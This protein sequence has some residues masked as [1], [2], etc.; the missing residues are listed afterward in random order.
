MY[1]P[2]CG[3]QNTDG[4]KFCRA[5]GTELEALALVLS[6]R[7]APPAEADDEPKTADDWLALRSDGVRNIATGVCLLVISVLIGVALALFL[8]ASFDAPW[9][10]IWIVLV[11][12][13]AVW[14]GIE[15]GR[16]I[17]D[18]LEAVSRLRMMGPPARGQAVDQTPRQLE[19]HGEPVMNPSAFKKPPKASVTEATTR[20]LDDL[21]EP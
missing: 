18:F 21:A 6:G 12:W 1:C 4:V 8:P 2:R 9:I 19:S 7:P 11:G 10:L 17:G 20:H 15:L 3:T 13:M 16:G 5:C 14:G